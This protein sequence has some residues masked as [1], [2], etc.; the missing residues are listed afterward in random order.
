MRGP[1]VRLCR[2]CG[3]ERLDPYLDF[4]A[5][6]ISTR[7]LER[8]DES[9]E[10]FGTGH[11]HCG[12]CGHVQRSCVVP[13]SLLYESYGRLKSTSLPAYVGELAREIGQSDAE[14]I[15][16]IGSNN[17]DFLA[18]VGHFGRVR[19][20]GVDPALNCV[21]N[22]AKQGIPTVPGYFVRSLVPELEREFGRPNIIVA[23]HVL[24]HVDDTDDFL[25][26]VSMLLRDDGIFVVEV[27][28]FDWAVAKGDF[29]SFTEE[30]IS[31]FS[32]R[33]LTILLNRY[34]FHVSSRRIVPDNWSDAM[35]Y[36]CRRGEVSETTER[37]I[38]YAT[39]EAFL[40]SMRECHERLTELPAGS[41][42]FGG[43]C[44]S[45]NLLNYLG[46]GHETPFQF[47]VDDQPD[48]Q[49]RFLPGSHLEVLPPSRLA[50]VEACVLATVNFEDRVIGNH[51]NFVR[52]GGKFV[53]LFPWRWR[54][55]LE[56]PARNRHGLY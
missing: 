16:E 5:Q 44:R 11:V 6:P 12:V 9:E 2:A 42:V 28:Y 48:K 33:S 39:R 47:A 36:T 8:I 50:E 54:M 17:G 56:P 43:F 30:H 23:R 32:D 41:A 26:A 3:S 35:L 21:E 10:S 53:Q 46:L 20:V 49:G 1:D 14:L 13:P 29:T 38:R 51:A 25:S 45:A 40:S 7:L 52:R 55:Q 24:E 34:G 31:Y 22:A 18:M 19:V 27:P 4:G 37:K 15:V